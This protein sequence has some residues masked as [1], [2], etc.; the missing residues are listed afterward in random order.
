MKLLIFFIL[1][2][3]LFCNNYQTKILNKSFDYKISNNKGYSETYSLFYNDLFYEEE[4]YKWEVNKVLQ[5]VKNGRLLDVCCGTG[6]HYS[7]LKHKL[8]VLGIDISKNMINKALELNPNGDFINEDIINFESFKKF[9]GIIVFYDGIFY[10]KNWKNI[11]KKSITLLKKNSNLF[12]SFLD[13]NNLK[14]LY[15]RLI[16]NNKILYYHG[17][18]SGTIYKEII[19]DILG[20]IIYE[21]IHRLY[22]PDEKEFLEEMK[23]LT[24]VEKIRYDKFDA[25]DEILYIFKS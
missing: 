1:F 5:Y 13:K 8:S 18:W 15:L 12:I 11:L 14:N 22:L 17:E 9:D 25:K 21:N 3:Y 19:T 23:L 16:Y 10:N 20:N 24:L 6:I 2:I 4:K 7:L